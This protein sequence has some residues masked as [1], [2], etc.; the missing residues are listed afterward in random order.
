[1][2]PLA[3]FADFLA[4]ADEGDA[5]PGPSPYH[6]SL[7]NWGVHVPVSLPADDEIGPYS[8][9]G[10]LFGNQNMRRG[11]RVESQGT[12]QEFL[13]QGALSV[14]VVNC[15][16]RDRCFEISVSY[17]KGHCKNPMSDTEV[18][19]KFRSLTCDLLSPAQTRA[20]LDRL[21]HL[22]EVKDIGEV[23]RMTKI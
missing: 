3:L 8:S 13:C 10:V 20:L 4:L 14:I 9:A 19:D 22:E 18:E 17:H 11:H 12:A 23:I 16:D 6:D 21:W 15:G 5:L 2:A 7:N 1:M